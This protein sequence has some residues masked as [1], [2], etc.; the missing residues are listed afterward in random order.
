MALILLDTFTGGAG[1][2]SSHTS[3]NGQTWG[4]PISPSVQTLS[5]NGSG[6]VVCASSSDAYSS[7]ALVTVPVEAS[8]EVEISYANLYDEFLVQLYYQDST[9]V[10]RITNWETVP[11]DPTYTGHINL[12][13]NFGDLTVQVVA[14]TSPFT[15]KIIN[16]ATDKTLYVNSIEVGSVSEVDGGTT[17]ETVLFLFN[18]ISSNVKVNSFTIND[19]ISTPSIFWQDFAGT[20]EWEVIPD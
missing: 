1:D 13:V 14:P 3:D 6:A 9:N 2:L 18:T 11:S 20:H 4:I 7:A 16:T 5:L 19:L 15:V 10:L 12:D 17:G 8:Y